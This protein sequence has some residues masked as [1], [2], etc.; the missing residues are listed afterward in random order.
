MNYKKIDDNQYEVFF[1]NGVKM[2]EFLKEVDGSFYFFPELKGGF[3]AG[4]IMRELADKEDELNKD[5]NNEI[6]K[7]F[8]RNAQN[9]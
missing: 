6:S 2:G 7:Y 4:Y 1:E 9:P 5:W 8:E 3:W